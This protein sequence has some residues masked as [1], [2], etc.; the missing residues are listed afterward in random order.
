[1]SG[2]SEAGED[3]EVGRTNKSEERTLLVA[4]NGDPD[5][6]QTD[7]VLDVSIENNK[8]LTKNPSGVDAIHATGTESLPT[9]GAI[10]TI[11]EGNGVVARGLNGVVGYVHA[12][13][14][15]RPA[16]LD[17]HAGVHGIGDS[18]SEGVYGRGRNGVVGYETGA[19][20]D[21]AWEFSDPCG[22]A[23]NG[24]VAGIGV[25]GTGGN[26]GIEGRSQNGFGV[27]GHSETSPGVSGTSTFGI[28]VLG[29]ADDGDGVMGTSRRG[30]GGVFESRRSAQLF[31]IPNDIGPTN[32][33]LPMTPSA[34]NVSDRGV[35]LP[36][37]GRG[38]ELMAVRDNQGTCS[39]WF[40]VQDGPPAM[41]AQVLTGHAFPGTA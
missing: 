34:I 7:F 17:V 3:L 33:S 13:T 14:R 25:R 39:L 37:R 18:T 8:V 41:W 21:P 38:G 20:R 19:A 29:A 9:G 10:G 4:T 35:P 36:A 28:G 24:G 11:P 1:M 40:C 31:L 16:E 27:D 23:G 22:V 26:G 32:S 12:A 6:Y 15:D 5:G 2:A 30:N